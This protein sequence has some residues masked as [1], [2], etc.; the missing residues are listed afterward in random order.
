M[1]KTHLV[2]FRASDEEKDYLEGEARRLRLETGDAISVSDIIRSCIAA[3]KEK[4]SQ[5]KK[6]EHQK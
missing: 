4:N 3:H 1:A 2:A 6:T 5:E